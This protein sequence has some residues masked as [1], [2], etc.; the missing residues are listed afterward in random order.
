MRCIVSLIN[1]LRFQ[2]VPELVECDILKMVV[3]LKAKTLTEGEKKLGLDKFMEMT[4]IQ[5][6]VSQHGRWIDLSLAGVEMKPLRINMRNVAS[7][8]TL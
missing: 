1:P 7:I 6:L 5:L 4:P 8:Q 2:F 3:E